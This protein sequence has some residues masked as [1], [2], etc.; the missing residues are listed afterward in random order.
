M[1]DI[2]NR[3][4]FKKLYKNLNKKKIGKTTHSILKVIIT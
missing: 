1:T 3:A 4:P 2:I